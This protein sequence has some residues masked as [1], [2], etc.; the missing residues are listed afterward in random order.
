M[1][2]GWHYSGFRVTAHSED[3]E[4]RTVFLVIS[5]SYS[6]ECIWAAIDGAFEV[7]HLA[8]RP[9]RAVCMGREALGDR[10]P[11]LLRSE[12]TRWRAREDTVPAEL[13]QT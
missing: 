6:D 11:A 3:G 2:T 9:V 10:I 13:Y 12:C 1:A 4:T 8:W 7:V 5:P